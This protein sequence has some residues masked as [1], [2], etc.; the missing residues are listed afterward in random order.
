MLNWRFAIDNTL[1][2]MFG[3]GIPSLGDIYLTVLLYCLIVAVCIKY[4]TVIFQTRSES[5]RVD[6]KLRYLWPFTF[7]AILPAI[8]ISILLIMFGQKTAAGIAFV[9]LWFLGLAVLCNLALFG[10]EPKTKAPVQF[11][12]STFG[13]TFLVTLAS[14]TAIYVF[15]KAVI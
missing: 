12:V 11:L 14:I 3:V 2:I 1:E 8:T 4:G 10:P 6:R 13:L 5:P 7:L 9:A 15:V